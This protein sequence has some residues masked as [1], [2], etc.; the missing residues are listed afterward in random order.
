MSA[1]IA[2]PSDRIAAFCERWQ[3]AEFADGPTF[4]AFERNRMAQLAIPKAGG[5][6]GKAASRVGTDTRDAHS[7]IPWADIVGM[8]NRLVHGYFDVNLARV[9]ETVEQDIPVPVRRIEPLAPSE[10]E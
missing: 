2:M 6:V 8:R 9:W 3:V 5:T 4:A 10:A 1:R 7:E